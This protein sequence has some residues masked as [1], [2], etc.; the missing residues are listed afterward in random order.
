MVFDIFTL[1]EL[2]WLIIPA[3]AANGLAPLFKGKHMMDFGKTLKKQPVFGSGK[4]WEGFIGGVIVGGVIGLVEQ[5][6]YPLLPWG[7]SPQAL[8]LA[9]MTLTLGLFLGLGAMTG[10][11][12]GAF[13]KRRCG[14]DRGRPAPLLD[15]EDFIIGSIF[16][17]RILTPIR[18]EWFVLAFFMTPVLH[19]IANIIA[20]I[21]KVKKEPW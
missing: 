19:I 17:A 7:L 20:Y 1:V 6:A 13:I 15:Q 5:L 8:N 3:Y 4:T 9:P 21:L 14:I 2:V 11:L 16:F 18:P 12:C 10:D